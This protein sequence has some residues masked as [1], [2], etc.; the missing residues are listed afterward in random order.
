MISYVCLF[1]DI[2]PQ[3]FHQSNLTFSINSD[4]GR[5]ISKGHKEGEKN[6]FSWRWSQ[7][8]GETRVPILASP[9]ASDVTFSKSLTFSEL[10]FPVKKEVTAPIVWGVMRMSDEVWT[11]RQLV[12]PTLLHLHF[13]DKEVRFRQV[14]P[15]PRSHITGAGAEVEP[16]SLSLKPSAPPVKPQRAWC[17]VLS[18][19]STQPYST[20]VIVTKDKILVSQSP[21][22]LKS[23]TNVTRR[24]C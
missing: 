21:F 16:S 9:L 20:L 1:H 18:V 7:E 3:P 19:D 15:C 14:K 13:T 12:L 4:T 10:Q 22:T 6:I 11:T 8:R 24:D 17:N 5:E 2:F 23:P